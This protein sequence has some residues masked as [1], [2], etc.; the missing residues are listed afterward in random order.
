[1]LYSATC[2][3]ENT[4]P[5]FD[6]RSDTP[7][8]FTL[9][10][11]AKHAGVSKS[12]LSKLIKTGKISAERQT[13]GEFRIDPS[14]LERISEIRSQGRYENGKSERSDTLE[15]TSWERERNLLMM[16]LQDRERQIQDLRQE[17]DAWRQQ[18][19]HVQQTLVLTAGAK[20]EKPSTRRWWRWRPNTL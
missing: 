18:A 17:R 20:P 6:K 11:A 12:Y 10:Q 15:K 16:L 1:M 3:Y 5:V 4:C 9:G 8:E 19:E 13:N 7:M 2:F 14:E